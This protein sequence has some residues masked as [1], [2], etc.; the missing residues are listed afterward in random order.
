MRDT[1]LEGHPDHVVLSGP[2]PVD[3]AEIP[4]P[5]PAEVR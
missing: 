2:P 1:E 5:E 3:V 4:G